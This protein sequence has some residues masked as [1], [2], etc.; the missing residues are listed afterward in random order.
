MHQRETGRAVGRVDEPSGDEGGEA[1]LVG[2]TFR[3]EAALHHRERALRV[4]AVDRRRQR[5]VRAQSMVAAA[6][7][8]LDPHAEESLAGA[9]L[10][11]RAYLDR[12]GVVAAP[13]HDRSSPIA[14]V[15][16][17]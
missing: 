13:E 12:G 5:E 9:E 8:E 3:G 7:V 1:E 10:E 16:H 2:P 14:C 15:G 11:R 17:S 4:G 6:V